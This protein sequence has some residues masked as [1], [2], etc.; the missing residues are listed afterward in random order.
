ME[1][2]EQFVDEIVKGLP[3]DAEE[4]REIREEFVMHLTEHAND[5]MLAGYPKEEAIEQAIAAFGKESVIQQEMHKVMFPYYKFV[6]YGFCTVAVTG[7]LSATSHIMTQYYFPQNDPAITIGVFL[8]YLALCSIVL[9]LIELVVEMVEQAG[10]HRW[11]V[12]PWLLLLLPAVILQ[13]ALLVNEL[14][15]PDV[16]NFWI[17]QDYVFYPLYVIFYVVCRQVFTWLFVRKNVQQGFVAS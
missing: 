1:R 7:L 4:Q 12:N 10:R 15:K 13:V 17:Y 9:G 6:R 5:L 2:M 8:A 3:L 11:F 16:T 14:N